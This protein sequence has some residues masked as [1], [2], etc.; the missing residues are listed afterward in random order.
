MPTSLLSLARQISYD[1][2]MPHGT[3]QAVGL[4]DLRVLQERR[5][6]TPKEHP[7]GH[8]DHEAIIA[9][10][11]AAG[12][13]AVQLLLVDGDRQAREY[14]LPPNVVQRCGTTPCDCPDQAKREEAPLRNAE[15]H[16]QRV[17]PGRSDR[18]TPPSTVRQPYLVAQGQWR[19]QP[20]P[21]VQPD[22]LEECLSM[23]GEEK[24]EYCKDL[25]FGPPAAQKITGCSQLWQHDTG[26]LATVDSSRERQPALPAGRALANRG[27]DY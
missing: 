16:V 22:N 17:S 7:L 18:G 15:R 11:R 3:S 10:Q 9:L 8:P 20:P 26:C 12:N 2:A 24:L 14:L 21:V 5:V 4:D 13:A 25:V 27:S 19:G 23:F 6:G 1:R